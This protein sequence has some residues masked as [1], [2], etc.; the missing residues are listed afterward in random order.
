MKCG[1]MKVIAS[2]AK[3]FLFA[4]PMCAIAG[5]EVARPDVAVPRGPFFQSGASPGIAMSP[6]IPMRPGI[7]KIKPIVPP[8]AYATAALPNQYNVLGQPAA[9][10]AISIS[11]SLKQNMERIAA[12]YHWQLIW[13]PNV[14]YNFD[15]R[16][17]GSS[18]PNV[19]EKLLKP[20]P[21]KADMYIGNRKLV[22]SSRYI[23]PRIA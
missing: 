14:D 11:G 7:R 8:T 9:R 6:G 15:G 17:T 2:L 12:Q 22:I 23:D 1:I 19:I 5:W 18:L 3:I 4:M 13:K 16:V 21:L 10:Y 20:F